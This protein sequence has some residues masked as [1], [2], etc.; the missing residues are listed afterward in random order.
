VGN[1]S[2]LRIANTG[3]SLLSTSISQFHLNNILHC[4]N[5]SS[6]LLSIQ[7]FC[8]DNHC[9]FI[10]TSTHFI[11]KDM[12]TK[13]ILLQGSN[14]ASLYPIYLT[15]LQSNKIKSKAAFLSTAAFLPHFT[16][17]LGVTASFEI[18]HSH[19]GHPGK[20]VIHRLLQQSLLS[21]SGSVKFNKLCDSCQM[22]KSKKLPF[23]DSHRKSTHP[24]ELIHSDVW[25]SPI[26]SPGGCKFYV[27][28]IDDHSVFHGYLP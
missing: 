6:N 19:L 25:T 10:L 8:R 21:C 2:G 27:V 9:Y 7:K 20:S 1:G 28:F 23:S 17:F 22:A 12:Q 13:E 16:A 15:Q 18:G 4:P 24:L 14:E 5:A 26:M 11:I 3:S